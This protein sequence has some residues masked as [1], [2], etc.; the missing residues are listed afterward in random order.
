MDW[1]QRGWRN[2]ELPRPAFLTRNNLWETG[3]FPQSEAFPLQL[4]QLTVC[5]QCQAQGQQFCWK[6]K[7]F[8]GVWMEKGG[9]MAICTLCFTFS[10]LKSDLSSLRVMMQGLITKKMEK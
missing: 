3:K 1:E 2:T 4:G 6:D 7:C 9:K 5:T 10:C 8:K